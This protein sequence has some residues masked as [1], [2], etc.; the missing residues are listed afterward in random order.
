MINDILSPEFTFTNYKAWDALEKIGNIINGVPE[1]K[2][3]F[4]TI[5]FRLLDEIPDLFYDQDQFEDETIR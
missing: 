3:D 2:D 4:K 1:I 5:T